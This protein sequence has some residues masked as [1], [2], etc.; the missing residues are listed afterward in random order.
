MSSASGTIVQ[1]G[2]TLMQIAKNHGI[3]FERLLELNPQFRRDLGHGNANGNR[4]PHKIKVGEKIN[5]DGPAAAPRNPKN[6]NK[7]GGASHA[8]RNRTDDHAP[9]GAAYVPPKGGEQRIG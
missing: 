3:S 7:E 8:R 2:D 1:K 4:D 5:V 6:D 9:G